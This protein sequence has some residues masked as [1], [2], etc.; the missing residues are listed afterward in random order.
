MF[1]GSGALSIWFGVGVHILCHAHHNPFTVPKQDVWAEPQKQETAFNVCSVFCNM[2]KN[3]NNRTEE[4]KRLLFINIKSSDFFY[5]ML[6]IESI[7][8][9]YHIGFNIN[10]NENLH[11][12]YTMCKNMWPWHFILILYSHSPF[13]LKTLDLTRGRSCITGAYWCLDNNRIIG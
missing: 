6:I 9:I 8:H 2:H 5:P 10:M 13:S 4:N 3:N 12:D 1:V 11:N 7:M